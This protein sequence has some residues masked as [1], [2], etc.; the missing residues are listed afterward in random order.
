MNLLRRKN[1]ASSKVMAVRS[2]ERHRR[3]R[4][5]GQGRGMRRSSVSMVPDKTVAGRSWQMQT[6]IPK[7][8]AYCLDGTEGSPVECRMGGT[9]GIRKATA[10]SAP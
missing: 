6:G 10:A 2:S 9:T 1:K 3:D 4:A 5:R 8:K 7:G